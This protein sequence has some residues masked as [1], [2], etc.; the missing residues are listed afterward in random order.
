MA[1][2]NPPGNIAPSPAPSAARATANPR[3]VDTSEWLA[4][5]TIQM[6][7]E[8]AMPSRSPTRSMSDP[9]STVLIVYAILNALITSP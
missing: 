3:N 8:I 9:H 5:E 7:T 2:R 1:V 6:A 4:L